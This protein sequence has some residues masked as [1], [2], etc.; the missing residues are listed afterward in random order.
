MTEARIGR[1][2]PACLHQ[3]ISDV[4]PE[5]LEY[6]E[7]WL[8]PDGL[9][10]GSIGLAPV[11]RRARVSPDRRRCVSRRGRRGRGS[12]RRRGRWRVCRLSSAGWA[13]PCRSRFGR[14]SPCGSLGASSATS[15]PRVQ[16]P[17]RSSAARRRFESRPRCSAPSG[18]RR[19]ARSA[20]F[21]ALWPSKPSDVSMS[22][23]TAAWTPAGR[24]PAVRAS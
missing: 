13:R 24:P 8:S 9:R 7:E 21:T 12:W 22:R 3:A 16:R 1:L 14:S 23:L 18:S 17:R 5:R 6:Y 19:A 11:T 4:L 15:S 10:D 20:T 2:L